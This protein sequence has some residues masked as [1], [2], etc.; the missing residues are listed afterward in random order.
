MKTRDFALFTVT[1]SFG[2]GIFGLQA[3]GG[4]DTSPNGGKP[5]TDSGAADQTTPP[6]DTGNGSDTS[7]GTDT[8]TNPDSS[9]PPG[10]CGFTNDSG[11]AFACDDPTMC[12]G[13]SAVCCL[14]GNVVADPVCGT[15]FGSQVKGTACRT[16]CGAG[17]ALLCASDSDCATATGKTCVPFTTKG[18]SFGFCTTSS[19]ADGGADGG[20]DCGT[21][22]TLHPTDGGVGPFCPF[23]DS[24]TGSRSCA[25]GQVCCHA[26]NTDPE[27]CR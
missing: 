26:N 1:L 6:A 5:G 16:A 10:A 15:F 8:G 9:P 4:D 13:V 25:L 21:A 11:S 24:G 20:A 22:P 14:E 7:S 3:C 17:E 23:A 18:H 12:T 2:L 19:A 27:T